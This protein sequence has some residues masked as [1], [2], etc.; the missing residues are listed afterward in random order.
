MSYS[1]T[2]N[3]VSADAA[4]LGA[5]LALIAL[6]LYSLPGDTPCYKNMF[7]TLI[8]WIILIVPGYSVWVNVHKRKIK[9]NWLLHAVV[10]IGVGSSFFVVDTIVGVLTGYR[11][12]SASIFS[13]AASTGFMFGTTLCVCPGF[14][15]IAIAGWVR[16]LILNTGAAQPFTENKSDKQP[17]KT[18]SI[19]K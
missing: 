1:K 4:G 8:M 18:G 3:R 5:L 15:F 14:T 6:F 9:P 17:K 19:Q 16:S 12:E 2:I 7:F 13:A 10:S 11:F